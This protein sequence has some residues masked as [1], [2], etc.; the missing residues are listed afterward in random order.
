MENPH[1]SSPE[2]YSYCRSCWM[3]ILVQPTHVFG[4]AILKK[5]ITYSYSIQII[6]FLMHWNPLENGEKAHKSFFHFNNSK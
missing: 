4:E 6:H 3:T 5:F 1:C 2:M